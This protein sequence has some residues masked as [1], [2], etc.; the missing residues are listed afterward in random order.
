MPAD[1]QLQ[2]SSSDKVITEQPT[3]MCPNENVTTS[4]LTMPNKKLSNIT[5]KGAPH[6]MKNKAIDSLISNSS[7]PR[8]TSKSN[9]PEFGAVSTQTNFK[10]HGL[11]NSIRK[12][13][14]N[15]IER[16]A[17]S[18]TT[19]V[20]PI[21][22]AADENKCQ[23]NG[24]ELSN[25][26]ADGKMEANL[27]RKNA[28]NLASISKFTRKNVPNSGD[29]TKPRN[30]SKNEEV[31]ISDLQAHLSSGLVVLPP[32]RPPKPAHLI[33]GDQN[34]S[35]LRN[36][37]QQA[38]CYS[39]SSEN[40]AN[41]A[42][43]QELYIN[44]QNNN[45]NSESQQL[46]TF[47][48]PTPTIQA[49]PNNNAHYNAELTLSENEQLSNTDS[50]G[51]VIMLHQ[52]ELYQVPTVSRELK[53]NR[54]NI[55]ARNRSQTIGCNMMA[56]YMTSYD[57]NVGDNQSE[58]REGSLSNV[59]IANAVS[60]NFATLG[61]PV[62]RALKPRSGDAIEGRSR[63]NSVDFAALSTRDNFI[64]DTSNNSRRNSAEDE[65]IYY[66]MPP[67]NTTSGLGSVHSTHPPHL[68]IPA[69]SFEH[70]S[71]SYID[72]DLP[73]TTSPTTKNNSSNFETLKEIEKSTA[74]K[75]DGR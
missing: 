39:H 65:Q 75:Q 48:I 4:T 16:N 13:R 52:G 50:N 68:M 7:G 66:Y 33:I 72:L 17:V 1:S 56:S 32:E 34:N 40:Y 73:R 29:T 58:N 26:D 47:D 71:I 35:E 41:A 55:T 59:F 18:S 24:L 64:E 46:Q 70:P 31:T 54:R 19:N 63:F 22:H 10:S 42:D 5:H 3:V 21:S 51:G 28:E 2:D 74:E 36:D 6:L 49:H 69:A 67:V 15:S 20:N 14:T 25:M 38:R 23:T 62:V 60:H 8:T 27:Q 53:P 45:I 11:S 57:S 30:L 44:E 12:L 37:L 9:K 43:M 61:P